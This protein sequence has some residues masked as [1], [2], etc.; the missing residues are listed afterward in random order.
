VNSAGTQSNDQSVYSD[1]HSLNAQRYFNLLCIVYGRDPDHF[2]GI[3]ERGMLP[4]ERA[5][6][7]PEES[8][9][10]TR[11]WARLLLPHFSPRFQPHDEPAPGGNENGTTSPSRGQGNGQGGNPLEWD[12]KSNPFNN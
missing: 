6:R 7:C 12:R 3:V 9:K 5:S 1:E 8:A 11:S 10:I 2:S 4:K